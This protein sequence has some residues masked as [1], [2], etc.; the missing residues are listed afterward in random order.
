MDVKSYLADTAAATDLRTTN[1]KFT[2]Y[3]C[4]C[5]CS[6]DRWGSTA[7]ANP[8]TPMSRRKQL[9]ITHQLVWGLTSPIQAGSTPL[10]SS[11]TR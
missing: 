10:H 3:T 7:A 1:P 8:Q 6:S 5:G 11:A 9:P 2:H 4:L